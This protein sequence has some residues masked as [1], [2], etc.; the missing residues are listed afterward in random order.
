MGVQVP[1]RT[2]N[3][4]YC[5]AGQRPVIAVIWQLGRL[6]IPDTATPKDTLP[7]ARASVSASWHGSHASREMTAKRPV[8]L[9][10]QLL[11]PI[12]SRANCSGRGRGTRASCTPSRSAPGRRGCTVPRLRG[13]RSGRLRP[14]TI[15]SSRRAGAGGIAPGH[16]ACPRCVD[17]SLPSDRAYITC[18]LG[19]VANMGRMAA[20]CSPSRSWVSSRAMKSPVNPPPW[21]C[22]GRHI[23]IAARCPVRTRR[24]TLGG[25]PRLSAGSPGAGRSGGRRRTNRERAP[26]H[27][28]A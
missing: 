19:L 11:L 18:G 26:C 22:Y 8:W 27:P 1:P 14:S 7:T 25:I 20:S 21:K 13:R 10:G 2:L 24:I 6:R 17:C 16:A 23:P 3:R 4:H 9:A 28:P 5:A 12:R 15:R